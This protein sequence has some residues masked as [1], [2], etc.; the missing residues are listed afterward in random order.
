MIHVRIVKDSTQSH[1]VWYL[2]LMAT[3]P[4]VLCGH[5]RRRVYMRGSLMIGLVR[6]PIQ[7]LLRTWWYLSNLQDTSIDEVVDIL[8]KE[9]LLIPG[10]NVL[11]F[12]SHHLLSGYEI[13][14]QGQTVIAYSSNWLSA[15]CAILAGITFP[16]IPWP[17]TI[18]NSK[19]ISLMW[20]ILWDMRSHPKM[21][22]FGHLMRYL[23]V[24]SWRKSFQVG[25]IT[26]QGKKCTDNP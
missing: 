8:R 12:Q 5:A 20:L 13:G 4:S 26:S 1:S 2:L 18:I 16:P 25:K 21:W 7:V 11:G 15:R 14:W 6:V 17:M 10:I 19:R 24:I 23:D 9:F 22:W 3:F